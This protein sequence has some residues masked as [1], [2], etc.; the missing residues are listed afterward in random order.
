[1][2]LQLPAPVVPAK[3]PGEDSDREGLPTL[4][5]CEPLSKR[6]VMTLCPTDHLS[7]FEEVEEPTPLYDESGIYVGEALPNLPWPLRK[8][9]SLR[10]DV[11]ETTL[12]FPES[13]YEYEGFLPPAP[14]KSEGL[15]IDALQ[16]KLHELGSG[17]KPDETAA[18]QP[19]GKFQEFILENFSIY[20]NSAISGFEL[21]P[22]QCL[23]AKVSGHSQYYF[24]GVLRV[25]N[26]R[27]FLE[28][29][30]F[31]ELSVG[32]YGPENDSVDGQ[33]WI[34]SSQNDRIGR[35]LYYKL[36]RPPSAMRGTFPTSSGYRTSRNT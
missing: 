17:P 26:E 33:V 3:R 6:V 24:D 12:I 32:N 9:N 30:P 18:D 27:Y 10:V 22:L 2:D 31:K 25:G 28:R 21:K 4:I 16:R 20:I 5:G 14:V 34:R 7:P 35:E 29:I 13:L 11:P 19:E 8:P 1:M 36:G 15:A 23:N